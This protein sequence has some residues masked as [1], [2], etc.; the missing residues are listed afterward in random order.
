MDTIKTSTDHIIPGTLDHS[1]GVAVNITI[2]GEVNI[3]MGQIKRSL[4]AG[5]FISSTSQ[6]PDQ[7]RILTWSYQMSLCLVL[8]ILH[9]GTE[10]PLRMINAHANLPEPPRSAAL[11]LAVVLQSRC[12][13]QWSSLQREEQ[14]ACCRLRS[15]ACCRRRCCLIS[16][17]SSFSSSPV[18]TRTD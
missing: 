1:Q 7:P 6:P 8:L 14:K 3:V 9:G 12:W 16:W 10:K 13:L 15:G 17:T 2:A 5:V 18:R 11:N 4:A